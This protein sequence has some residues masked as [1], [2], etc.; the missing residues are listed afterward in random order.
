MARPL[1]IYNSGGFEKT[2]STAQVTETGVKVINPRR[3]E[4]RIQP[5]PDG[6][7]SVIYLDSDEEEVTMEPSARK[8][9]AVVKGTDK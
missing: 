5:N 9:S 4:A 6:T 2:L 7:T 3:S 8:E 1:A